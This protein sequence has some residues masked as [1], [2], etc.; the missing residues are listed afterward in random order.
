MRRGLV[1]SSEME[2]LSAKRPKKLGSVENN[3]GLSCFA[4][5]GRSIFEATTVETVL[6]FFF[7]V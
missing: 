5:Q 7:R 6:F 1:L 4:G 2:M 3:S